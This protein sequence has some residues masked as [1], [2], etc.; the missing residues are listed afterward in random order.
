MDYFIFVI[1]TL[2]EKPKICS[3]FYIL[4]INANTAVPIRVAIEI[5]ALDVVPLHTLRAE[6]VFNLRRCNNE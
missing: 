6:I 5:V 4:N 3:F 2:F 1:C